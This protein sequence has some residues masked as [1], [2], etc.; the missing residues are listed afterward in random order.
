MAGRIPD[1]FIQDLLAR[2]DI[3][4]VIGERLDLKKAGREFRT[5]SPFTNEKTP[6]FFVNPVKQMFFDFSS[7]KNGTAISF[8]MEYDRL[9]FVEAVEE[10]A[11]RAGVVVPREGGSAQA[12][13]PQGPL[14]A[15]ARAEDFF[16]AELRRNQSAIEYLKGRG[17]SGET[18]RKF[19][20]G[21]APDSWD[22][23]A[24]RFPDPR[25]ALE[26]GLLVARDGGGHYDRFR[27]RI[28]FPIRDSAGQVIAFGG[29]TL[30]DD[31]AKYLNS[32][33][34]PL[35]SKG[36]NLYG[37]YEA[38][39]SSE[40]LVVEGYMDCV[41]L[42]QH[43]VSNTVATLGTAT[44][45]D[46]LNLLFRRG[47]DRVVFCFDGDRAGRAAAWRALE[48]ALPEVYDTRECL[49]MFLPEGEDPDTFVQKV[50][51][52]EF[53]RTHVARAKPLPA[54]LIDEL[55]A[56]TNPS[57]PQGRSRLVA[58]A[59]PLLDRV[60]AGP[61][62]TQL[63]YE[64]A[65]RARL[66][67]A[68]FGAKLAPQTADPTLVDQ[69]LRDAAARPVRRALQL[70]LEQ[71]A[72]AGT[73]CNLEQLAQADAPGIGLLVAVI[74]YFRDHPDATAARL[75]ELWREEERGQALGRVA[76]EPLTLGEETVGKDF[77]DAIAHLA[78]KG[79]RARAQA[80]LAEARRRDLSPAEQ[81]ELDVLSR[82]LVG[83]KSV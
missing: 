42:H 14:E 21:Y 81:K 11:K 16:K 20:I 29:R 4:Q 10:L 22:A 72:L 50:G 31:P 73:V 36:K 39:R 83:A 30:G 79:L 48:Q 74:E 33:E 43:G 15:L 69:G 26:A 76:M 46:H 44:T 2:T 53:R 52:E 5:R 66:T 25:H 56:Q 64:L 13:V 63:V 12:S 65:Q 41:M 80:L 51:S 57:T 47:A 27:N 7:G 62:K 45:R 55:I 32:P 60:R 24:K 75:L 82:Q 17:V 34:T 38:P 9:T 58:M 6:S 28:M 1:S 35:F 59:R 3:V 68:E 49:F 77:A 18:A 23:L 61:L 67:E 37:L 71:P 19:G 8:L 54:F 40:M 70:L 78:Q